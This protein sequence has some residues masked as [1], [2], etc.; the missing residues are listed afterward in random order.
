[1]Q[2][3]KFK[4]LML[5]LPSSLCEKIRDMNGTPR[6]NYTRVV[7]CLKHFYT[8]VCGGVNCRYRIRLYGMNVP[9]TYLLHRQTHSFCDVDGCMNAVSLY[10]HR[11][12]Y[13]HADIYHPVEHA[14][15]HSHCVPREREN[16]EREFEF[17]W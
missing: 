3:D 10:E 1:M 13:Q 7:H 9:P 2:E 11:V 5:S 8:P 17:M 4:T 6:Q 12:C 15:H 16:D 14:Y